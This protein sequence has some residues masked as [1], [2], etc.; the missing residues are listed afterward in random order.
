LTVADRDR[1]RPNRGVC[2]SGIRCGHGACF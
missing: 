2:F 1:D